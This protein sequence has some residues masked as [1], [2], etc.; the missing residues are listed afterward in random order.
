M[1]GGGGRVNQERKLKVKIPAGIATGQRLRLSGEG[2]HGSPGGQQGDLY[3]VVQVQ[4]HEFFE[5]DGNDLHCEIPV[6]YTT[7]ALGGEVMVPGLLDEEETVSVP[8][9]PQP[10]APFPIPGK[11]VAGVL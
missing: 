7:L 1:C 3:V 2:E 9:G 11:G 4:D 6:N 10:G 8:A 5:R